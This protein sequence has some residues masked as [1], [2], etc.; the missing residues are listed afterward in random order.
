MT[1]GFQNSAGLDMDQ[2]FA[3]R[4]SA[5]AVTT[6]FQNAAGEDLAA[7]LQPL[8]GD[9]KVGTQGF[10]LPDGR[11][12]C[13]VFD[14]TA[15]TPRNFSATAS[16][17]SQGISRASCVINP[18]GSVQ[19]VGNDTVGW[20]NWFY[21]NASGIGSQYQALLT[22]GSESGT[23]SSTGAT[24]GVWTTISSG[25]TR[26]ISSSAAGSSERIHTSTINVQIRRLSDQ[27]VVCT[28]TLNLTTDAMPKGV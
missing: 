20:D 12:F 3:A 15:G 5:Q 10:Q 18:D 26:G 27:V 2:V 16:D 25:L 19:A 22:Q 28:G 17:A 24:L 21:P 4:V 7:K 8:S 9:P 23:G 6:G 14:T 1:T 11:D 13:Q